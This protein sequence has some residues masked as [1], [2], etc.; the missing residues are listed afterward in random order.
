M[1]E[2]GC[3]ISECFGGKGGLLV[4][5]VVLPCS[6]PTSNLAS[7]R[8]GGRGGGAGDTNQ[9]DLEEHE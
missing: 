7:G 1:Q 2:E 5:T 9:A 8:G 3:L 4:L 6:H